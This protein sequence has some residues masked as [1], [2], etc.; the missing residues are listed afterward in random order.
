MKRSLRRSTFI[1]LFTIAFI[2]GI[3]FFMVEL[4]LNADKWVNPEN[5]PY[6]AN[7][8]IYRE[9]GLAEAGKITDR[10]G[11]VL[12]DNDENGRVYNEDETV[13]R[14]LMH[15]VGDSST[16]IST[17]V[18][19]KYRA[20][21]NGYSLIWGM[22]IPES[23][24]TSRDIAL[25]VDTETCTAAYNMLKHGFE[26]PKR[27]AC[28]IYN[29]KTGE[30]IC[31]VSTPEYDPNDPPVITEENQDEYDG[32][33]LDNVLSSTYTPGSVFKIVTAAAALEYIPDI[34]TRTWTCTGSKDIGG[35]DINCVNGEVHGT[36]NLKQAMEESCNIVFAELAVELGPEKMTETANKMGINMRFDVDDLQTAKGHY[37][38]EGAD[39]NALAWTGVG[40]GF[41]EY[42]DKVNPMQMAI[43]CGS[44]ANGGTAKS[45]TYIKDG[46][47]DLLKNIG[48][49]Q[50]KEYSLVDSDIAQKLKD[51]MPS[52]K[53][54]GLDI[55][56]KTGTAEVGN[57]KGNNAWFV[58][59]ALNDDCPLAFACVVED[60]GFGNTYARPVVEAALET[61]TN[62]LRG[63]M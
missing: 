3:S 16:N 22:N 55:R 15:T 37:N 38:A 34:Y 60:A 4:V 57:G 62:N 5:P 10:N 2:I 41:G 40:Q 21:L 42:E 61:A 25:T 23:M 14:A 44:I 32:V 35:H 24:R 6:P 53:I 43:L 33:Y 29:Y 31:S 12:A 50:V 47:D 63:K 56:A 52:Y 46:A 49:K 48:I 39:D 51:V 13:R 28:V 8:H 54:A 27:G 45:A 59:Y 1:L 19:S 58:G 18:Q 36:I 9:N 20:D 30:V 17:A 26:E 7:Q 11:L